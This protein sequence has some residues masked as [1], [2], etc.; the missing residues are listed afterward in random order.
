MKKLHNSWKKQAEKIFPDDIDLQKAYIKGI[1]DFRKRAHEGVGSLN[2]TTN[3]KIY[4]HNGVLIVEL[5]EFIHDAKILVEQLYSPL[6]DKKKQIN[7]T[8]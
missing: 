7:G 6:M 2:I 1:S 4:Q 8:Y 5:H 3:A